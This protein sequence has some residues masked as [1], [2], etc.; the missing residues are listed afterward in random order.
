MS[1]IRPR[2]AAGYWLALPATL[3][4]MA[5]VVVPVGMIVWVSFWGGRAFS[6]DSPLTFDNY[7]RF[8]ANQHLSR[9]WW[10]RRCATP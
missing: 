4:M 9:T 6:A 10:P 5:A 8:F 3:W 7:Q 2:S 1:T